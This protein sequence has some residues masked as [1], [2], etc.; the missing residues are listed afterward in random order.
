MQ[1]QSKLIAN[2]ARKANIPFS[3]AVDILR[4]MSNMKDVKEKLYETK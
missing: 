1:S 2:V 4:K 3:K